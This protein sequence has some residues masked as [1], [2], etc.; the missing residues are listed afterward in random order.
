MIPRDTQRIAD[1][2]APEP[3]QDSARWLRCRK[4][5]GLTSRAAAEAT[6]DG[7]HSCASCGHDC[8]PVDLREEFAQRRRGVGGGP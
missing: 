5:R 4:C 2:C 3:T 1:P 7:H 8:D 6:A